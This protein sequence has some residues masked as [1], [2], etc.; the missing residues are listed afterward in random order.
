[1]PHFPE[2]LWHRLA[3]SDSKWFLLLQPP[4][5]LRILSL[6]VI[7]L[8]RRMALVVASVPELTNR[9]ISMLSNAAQTSS[10]MRTSSLV[11]VPNLSPLCAARATA[12]LTDS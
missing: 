7:P 4:A 8:A 5:T 6:P 11:G 9:T 3:K 1:M 10:A 2:Q 12:T